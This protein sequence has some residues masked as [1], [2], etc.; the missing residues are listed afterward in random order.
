MGET[1]RD[2]LSTAQGRRPRAVLRPREQFLPRRTDLDWSIVFYFFPKSFL[3]S[4]T[5]VCEVERIHVDEARDQNQNKSFQHDFLLGNFIL[6]HLLLFF[7]IKKGFCV[8][9]DNS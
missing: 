5:Y 7:R 8:L 2:V 1:V 9:L 6:W 4:P 3:H